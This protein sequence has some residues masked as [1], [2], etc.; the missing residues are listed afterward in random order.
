[1]SR[2]NQSSWVR[3]IHK[4]LAQAKA[5]DADLVVF[6]ADGHRYELAPPAGE[7]A[8]QA[9]E[10]KHGIRLPE[11]YRNFLI[12]IGD[13]GAGPY[14]GIFGLKELEQEI[15]D[16]WYY[17]PKEKPV[18]YPKMSD[19]DWDLAADPEDKREEE[20]LHPFAGILPIGDQGCTYMTGLVLE[21]PYCGR[22]VYFDLDRLGKPFFVREQG[23][24]AWYERWLREVIA[25]YEIFWFGMNLDGNE[26]QLMECYQQTDDQEEKELIIG[27]YYKFHKLPKKQQDY[28][29]QECDQEADMEI[30]IKLIK[31]LAH[32]HVK[33]MSRQIDKLW[34]HGAYKEAISVITYEGGWEEKEKWYRPILEKLPGLRGDAFRDACHTLNTLKDRPKVEIH[35]GML[36]E[37]LRRRDLNKNDRIV[38]FNSIETMR[39]REE[40]LD[41]FLDY[42]PTEKDMDLLNFGIMALRDIRDQRLSEMYI[43]LLEQ[44]RTRENAQEDYRRS[45][46]VLKSGYRIGVR[47][48]E[49]RIIVNL[50]RGLDFFELNE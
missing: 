6:G 42:L 31:M 44:Y 16:D 39:G 41:Y 35:A 47:T 50:M 24:L 4:L 22:V 17:H 23:F 45:Q 43:K 15:K 37:V 14:Y 49:G 46:T 38:L 11:E 33:G 21:G 26:Q 9:F 10:E 3:R 5:K 13:G 48:P 36:N 20:E 25:G 29:M 19:E 7:D 1:M 40:V 27:S 32:F 8:V 34:E 2:G 28:F 12:L 18:I 30:Q